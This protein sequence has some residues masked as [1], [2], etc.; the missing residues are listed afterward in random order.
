MMMVMVVRG[1]ED[2]RLVTVT[3]VPAGGYDDGGDDGGSSW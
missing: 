1:G 3:I 2:V